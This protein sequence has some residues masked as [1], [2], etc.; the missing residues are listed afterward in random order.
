M[1]WEPARPSALVVACSDG[2]LQAPL[3]DFLHHRLG[4]VDYDR[5]YAPGG[6]GALAV[7]A[8][9]FVRSD[10]FRREAAFLVTA[11]GIQDAYLIFHASSADGPADA[12]C[13]DYRRRL[14]HY[15]PAEI[16]AQQQRDAAEI[17]RSGIGFGIDVRLHAYRC[18]V[19]ADG[20][21]QVVPLA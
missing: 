12:T 3:D 14:P 9:N 13:G 10:Q 15:T 19:T 1:P 18:E 2:R 11:H 16:R 17:V 5:L 8:S 21:V 7:G 6:P 20:R 4:I